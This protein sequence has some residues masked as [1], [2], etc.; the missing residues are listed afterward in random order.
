MQGRGPAMHVEA[1]RR[2]PLGEFRN[3]LRAPRFCV[4]GRGAGW[5]PLRRSCGFDRTAVRPRIRLVFATPEPNCGKAL[6]QGQTAAFRVFGFGQLAAPRPIFVLGRQWQFLEARHARG[7]ILRPFRLRRNEGLRHCGLGG[8]RSWLRLGKQARLGWQRPDR[9]LL[10]TGR[11]KRGRDRGGRGLIDG[12]AQLRWL[13]RC[14]LGRPRLVTPTSTP[15]CRG[16]L[17]G[18]RHGRAQRLMLSLGA[19]GNARIIRLEALRQ[20]GNARFMAIG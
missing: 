8:R 14:K 13:S 11:R 16:G 1:V 18:G 7:A 12:G 15:V 9:D 5:R 10:A 4:A 17:G 6:Q 20:F 2:S 3:R 19:L